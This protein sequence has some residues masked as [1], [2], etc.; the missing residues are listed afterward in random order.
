MGKL[1]LDSPAPKRPGIDD[2]P[3]VDPVPQAA[4]TMESIRKAEAAQQE[5]YSKYRVQVSIASLLDAPAGAPQIMPII[6]APPNFEPSQARNPHVHRHQVASPAFAQPDRRSPFAQAVVVSQADRHSQATMSQVD[7]RSVAI[8]QFLNLPKVYLRVN[9]S[10]TNR[11]TYRR[12]EA[13]LS[14]VVT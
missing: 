12:I 4:I 2:T 13:Q 11:K 8:H 6:I 3:S 5:I 9:G 1:T 10:R 14:N 7:R